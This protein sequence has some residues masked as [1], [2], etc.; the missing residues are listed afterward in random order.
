MSLK[1]AK[2]VIAPLGETDLAMVNRLAGSLNS[3]FG[4]GVDILK[5]MRTPSEAYNETRNQ[6]YARIILHSSKK[7]D[8]ANDEQER[9][10]PKW[11]MIRRRDEPQSNTT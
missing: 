5:G 3:V 4:R 11:T 8:N 6:Y 10:Q 9:S 1:R 2:I 7:T